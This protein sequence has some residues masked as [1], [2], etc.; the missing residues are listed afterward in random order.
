MASE[1][2]RESGN[3]RVA[4]E[5]RAQ[6][7]EDVWQTRRKEL[8]SLEQSSLDRVIVWTSS[9]FEAAR[10]WVRFEARCVATGDNLMDHLANCPRRHLQRRHANPSARRVIP[11]GGH[12]HPGLAQARTAEMRNG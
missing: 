11:P 3:E 7:A 8:S 12:T 2:V 6:R 10:G 1:T 4:E 5:R 9:G